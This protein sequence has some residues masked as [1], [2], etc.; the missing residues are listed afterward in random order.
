MFFPEARLKTFFNK[1]K[2]LAKCLTCILKTL[3]LFKCLDCLYKKSYRYKIYTYINIRKL[4]R[5][6]RTFYYAE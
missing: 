5:K 1:L 2:I 4:Y 3:Y 6:A